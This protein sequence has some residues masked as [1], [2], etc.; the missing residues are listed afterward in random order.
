M[1]IELILAFNLAL[2]A[3]LVSPGPALLMAIRTNLVKG[4]SAGIRFGAGVGLMASVWTMMAL[5]GL[6][7]VFALFPWAYV[8]MKIV[9]A[10]YLL[11]LAWNT[12]RK[13]C[14]PL[15][16]SAR[17][18]NHAFSEGFLLNMS[19]PKSVLFAATVLIVI[20][21][22]D[23]SFHAKAFIMANQFIVE[24]VS[25]SILAFV[26]NTRSVSE[27]LLSAKTH[28]DRFA[29]FILCGLGIR[30]LFQK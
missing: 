23:L 29:A 24:F 18:A 6:D 21:P 3:A 22:P 28:L 5:L 2:L 30:L 19:N 7:S 26:L 10:M 4:R 9:G 11:Y 20:F 13:A 16:Y 12:W 14:K 15:D 8:F 27:R 1:T 25:Y 17:A